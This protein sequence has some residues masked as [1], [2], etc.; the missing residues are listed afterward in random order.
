MRLG[1]DTGGTFT[2]FV[3]VDGDGRVRI[4]KQLSTPADPSAAI[5]SG[6]AAMRVSASTD[7]IHGSTVATNALLERRG[8]RTALVTTAGFTDVL[9]IGRQNRPDLYALTPQ[10]PEPL[11]PAAWRF[12]V[13]ERVSSQGDVL[14]PLDEDSVTAVLEAIQTDNIEAVAICLLFSFLRPDHERQIKKRLQAAN[15]ALHISLSC[16]ILPEY[17]EYERT[18]ATVIN[19][20]VAP[21]MGR[22]LSKLAD[23]LAPRRLSVM[24]SNG[25]IISAATAGQQAART[26]LSGPA[27][28]V[29]GA[30]FVSRQSG[31]TDIITFDMGGTSTDVALCPGHLPSTAEGEIADM[32]LRLPI[33]DIHTVGAGGG[34]LAAIDAGGA[35]HV[36]PQSAGADPGPVCYGRPLDGEQRLMQASRVTV[37][38]ANLVLG[39]LDAHHFLGGTMTLDETAARDALAELA[40]VMKVSTPEK[41]AWGV[42]QVAN[43]NMERA[44]RRISVERGHDPRRFTLVAFGGAG[45]LHACEL[46]E[47]LQIPRVLIPG[48][49]GVLSALGMLA[50]APTRDYSQTVMARREAWGVES[51]SWLAEQFAPLAARAMAEMAGEGLEETAVTLHYSLD[52]RYVGQSHELPVTLSETNTDPIGLFHDAHEARYGYRQAGAA[53]EMVT[54]RVTAVAT[55]QSPWLPIE[56]I[57]PSDPSAAFLGQKPVWFGG[58]AHTADCYDR[59]KL[60]PGNQFAGPAVVFQYDTTAVIPP[61]WHISVDAVGNLLAN[62]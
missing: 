57:G 7:V 24:Q 3:F 48:V 61:G 62:K 11:V 5:L 38:D 21:L 15:P 4:H 40:V 44:V 16:E 26:A 25:G 60:Q 32:P 55:I 37:T 22:Y 59:E 46:A 14:R 19:A 43:A 28:G 45:P 58:Q 30:R 2:D 53:V 6:V 18:A 50:A 1:V 47:T 31:F 51:A 52:M 27:G 10:K 20:Y 34:S 49:P 29:V 42:I 39:R 8:A 9:A 56:P 35:L 54:A 36:G 41:A 17:R 33:I 23:G 13:L 12:G